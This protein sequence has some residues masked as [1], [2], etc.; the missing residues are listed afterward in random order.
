MA[1]FTAAAFASHPWAHTAASVCVVLIAL[2]SLASVF[3]L[4]LGYSRIPFAAA[5]DG[6]FPAVFG[7][8]HAR[9]EFPV[10][11][12]LTLC[13]VTLLC[14]LF[15]LAEVIASLV[16]LR[17]LFQFLLQG[18]AVLLSRHRAE[19]RLPGRFRMP[20]YPLPTVLA[21]AGF[22]FILLSRPHVF[23]ELRLA[24]GVLLS[25]LLVYT[26][27]SRYAARPSA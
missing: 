1:S 15:R 9:R 2:A 20:L 22:V 24:G 3:A 14:C 4:L 7:K 19:R 23:A 16:V 13:G 5:R 21:M 17:I 12:L 6:N 8:L 18:V 10:V 27:R 25:G 26:V 11:S